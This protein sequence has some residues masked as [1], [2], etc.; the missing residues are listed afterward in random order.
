LT[1]AIT[2]SW[3][4]RASP[5]HRNSTRCE[6]I[7][8]SNE[9]IGELDAYSIASERVTATRQPLVRT[10]SAECCSGLC[11]FQVPPE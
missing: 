7:V 11:S 1:V 3:S 5:D 8:G 4:S 9:D 6:R 10:A 2:W